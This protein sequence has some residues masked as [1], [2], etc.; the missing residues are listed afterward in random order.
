MRKLETFSERLVFREARE[1][2]KK[3]KDSDVPTYED[4]KRFHN[5]SKKIEEIS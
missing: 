4:L 1:L 5:I 2:D 3:I